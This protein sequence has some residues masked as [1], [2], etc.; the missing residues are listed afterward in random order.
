[1]AWVAAEAKRLPG[2]RNNSRHRDGDCGMARSKGP[3]VD[4]YLSASGS[5]AELAVRRLADPVRERRGSTLA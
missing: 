5:Y 3:G 2:R 4:D 1:M